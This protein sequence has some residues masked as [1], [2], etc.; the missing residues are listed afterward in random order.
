MISLE[1]DKQTN[2]VVEKVLTSLTERQKELMYK[3]LW[4]ERVKE[5][6]E[7]WAVSQMKVELDDDKLEKLVKEVSQQYV[8]EGNYSP[9]LSYWENIETLISNVIKD[10]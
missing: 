1:Y 7:E 2:D 6:V 8:F 10:I 5:D 4:L 3:A 9:N